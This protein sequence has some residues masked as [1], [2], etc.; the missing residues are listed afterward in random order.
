MWKKTKALILFSW[1][2][3]SVLALKV[4]E[5]QWIDCTA[6]TFCTPFFGKDKAEQLSQ[7]NNIKIKVVDISIPHLDVVKNP[8]YWYGKNMNPCIDCHWFMIKTAFDIAE[9]EWFD[10]VASWEVLWQRPMSQ[11]SRGLNSVNK[12]SGR[13]VLRPLS[14][15]LLKETSY[16][17]NWLVDRSKLLDISWRGRQRQMQLAKEFGL[18]GYEMPGW[19][20]LLTQEWYSAKLRSLFANFKND[21]QS[22]DTEII[23]YGRLKVFDWWF[24]VMWRDNADNENLMRLKPDKPQY[25]LVHL[26]ETTWPITLINIIK[27]WF[28]ETEILNFYREKVQKLKDFET[29]SLS[30]I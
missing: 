2:L 20:C 19:W 9:K 30:Y 26:T 13:E 7:K 10:V 28:N 11:T 1:W 4:L 14:A 8:K 17:L 16:E 18:I 3:D 27:D 6:L 29:I 5:Q 22:I 24:C 12:I 25:K 15:K 21:I 23:K